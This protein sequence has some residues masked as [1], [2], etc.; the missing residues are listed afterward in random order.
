L[1]ISKKIRENERYFRNIG[2][3]LLQRLRGRRIEKP[4][5][6]LL[7]CGHSGTTVLLRLIGAHSNIYGVSYESRVFEYEN[8]KLGLT[9]RIWNREAVVQGKHRWAEKT[10]MHVRLIDRIFARYPD[11]RIIFMVRDG[12]DVT[13]SMRKR[14][15]E[16]QT[17]LE[18]W[19]EDNQCGLRWKDDPRVMLLRYEDLVKHYDET[20]PKICAFID[21]PFEAN[22]I[23]YH[24]ERAY[25]FGKERRGQ[26]I[27]NPGSGEGEDHKY[28][29][30]WQVNQ[31]LFDG[32][33]KW[34]EEM[35]DEEKAAFKANPEAMRLMAEL[36]YAE[37]DNW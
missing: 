1:G 21:E 16:F 23:D 33:G 11:A 30:N 9:T 26:E 14:F 5:I 12:R 22:L 10:P 35:S 6:L 18:R 27:V 13:V 8:F 36:G 29:R 2:K 7:G 24:Q 25:I 20:M 31:K 32:S 15:G 19:V 34:V 28:Y 3:Y 37:D 4:P 17:G